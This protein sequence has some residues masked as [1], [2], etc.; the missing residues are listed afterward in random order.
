MLEQATLEALQSAFWPTYLVAMAA[1]VIS[2]AAT[3]RWC[4]G[5]TLIALALGSATQTLWEGSGFLLAWQAI[6]IFILVTMPPRHYWQSTMAGLILAQIA[7]HAI[8]WLSPALAV[9]HWVGCVL[10]G[11]AKCAV[12]L[13]WSGGERV[14]SL[15][16]RF[17]GFI[18]NLVRI[19]VAAKPTR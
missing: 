8:W 13:L 12:L 5:R 14:E 7:L 10:L 16:G 3:R 17:A 18:T 19:P 11:F 15:L 4:L 2:F 1:G 9:E 6:P